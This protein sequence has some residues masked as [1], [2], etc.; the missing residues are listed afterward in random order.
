[1]LRRSIQAADLRFD[2][3]VAVRALE[4]NVGRSLGDVFFFCEDDQRAGNVFVGKPPIVRVFTHPLPLLTQGGF[5]EVVGDSLR[6]EVHRKLAAVTGLPVKQRHDRGT[7]HGISLL[8]VHFDSRVCRNGFY[9]RG[10]AGLADITELIGVPH[11]DRFA[12]HL[13]GRQF[14]IRHHLHGEGILDGLPVDG[15]GAG[16]GGNTHRNGLDRSV[17]SDGDHGGI[18][19]GPH[20][21][22]TLVEAV[23]V[24]AGGEGS[25]RR[26]PDAQHGGVAGGPDG[27]ERPLQGTGHRRGHAAADIL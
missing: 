19:A 5:V 12:V 7:G 9:L 20:G 23:I 17:G 26:L 8:H 2:G 1:M 25:L 13:E 6:A 11:L 14:Q 22:G 15:Y 27:L 24:H 4:Q 21:L 16:D 10:L 3:P 18:V